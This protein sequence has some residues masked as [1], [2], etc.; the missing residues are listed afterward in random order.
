VKQSAQPPSGETPLRS[1][2]TAPPRYKSASLEGWAPTLAQGPVSNESQTPPRASFRIARGGHGPP[3]PITAPL[4]G[5]F[6]A[7]TPAGVQVKGESA[8]LRAWE[9][10][11]ATAPPTLVAR[12]S[13]P[14]CDAVR[15]G[16]QPPRGTVPPT[17]V[18]PALRTLEKG[19]RNPRM[20]DAQLLYARTG[21]RRDVR[22]VG[23]VASVIGPM[24]PSRPLHH[25]ARRCGTC[26]D[27]TPP[28]QPFCL[29]RPHGNVPSN[30]HADGPRTS[31]L[32]AT[33]LEAAPGDAQDTP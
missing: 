22:T 25:H 32:N 30:P 28:R 14:L 7:L 12:P 29:V 31:N 9:S 19:R 8:S 21:W 17:P 13:P 10:R 4:A 5:A 2:G 16:Q 24:R 18:R 11:P 1:K 6:N 3:P 15:R 26:G 33:P 23:A 20:N 27:G